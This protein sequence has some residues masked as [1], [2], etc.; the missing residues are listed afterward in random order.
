MGHGSVLA[1]P[2]VWPLPG[3]CTEVQRLI[4]LGHSL[5]RSRD[6]ELC[7]IHAKLW[8]PKTLLAPHPTTASPQPH[9]IPTLGMHYSTLRISRFKPLI[10]SY[11]D[12]LQL[13]TEAVVNMLLQSH[14]ESL[15]MYSQGTA[16]C[17][18]QLCSRLY[19]CPKSGKFSLLP[20]CR[21]WW[22]WAC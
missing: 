4:E 11:F 6:F 16:A 13:S 12:C 8:F 7:C 22:C 19:G 9:D 10:W 1:H 3:V 5:L 21:S 17:L 2:L 15:G 14:L 20:C 18:S